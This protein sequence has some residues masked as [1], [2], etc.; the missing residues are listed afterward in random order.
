M[1]K[2]GLAFI[3]TSSQTNFR[4]LVWV[5]IYGHVVH[6]SS[7]SLISWYERV[8]TVGNFYTKDAYAIISGEINLIQ[9]KQQQ[10]T[11]RRWLT[12]FTLT[13]TY[14]SLFLLKNIMKGF[15]IYSSLYSD[16]VHI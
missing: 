10:E 7:C 15:I 8:A 9:L 13:K 11:T 3:S 4:T 5:L 1:F 6:V 14:S 16:C 2:S 12:I